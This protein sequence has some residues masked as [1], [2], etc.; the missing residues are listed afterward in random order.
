[1]PSLRSA[2]S[3]A[4]LTALL[5]L[6]TLLPAAGDETVFLTSGWD[7][8]QGYFEGRITLTTDPQDQALLRVVRER[9][10]EDQRL[11]RLEGRGRAS[12]NWVRA[13][14]ERSAG[15]AG[16]LAGEADSLPPIV[17]QIKQERGGGVWTESLS[18]GERT[19]LSRGALLLPGDEAPPAGGAPGAVPSGAPRARIDYPDDSDFVEQDLETD[20]EPTLAGLDVAHGFKRFP[21]ALF[22]KGE[23]DAHAVSPNDVAQGALGNCYL[24]AALIATARTDPDTIVSMI[25]DHQD[26]TYTVTFQDLGPFRRGAVVRVSD[27]IPVD[28]TG[29]APVFVGFGDSELRDGQRVRE[30]WPSV[31]EKAWAK[32]KG[33]YQRTGDFYS[34]TAFSF[35]G[36][37]A[38][39]FDPRDMSDAQLLEVLRRA[40]REGHPMTLG[41]DSPR[42]MSAEASAAMTRLNL[43]G[44]H[45]YALHGLKGNR[46]RL[47]NPWGHDHP[48]RAIKIS[49]IRELFASMSQGRY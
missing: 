8:T 24:L 22:I 23:G 19:S 46:V 43:H 17:M 27:A 37:S 42:N 18:D 26:G 4:P 14:F 9:R 13:L 31:I 48:T 20:A 41:T 29:Q 5:F 7:Y 34:A 15:A 12:G 25:Q 40:E 30:I 32:Y 10:F 44:Y 38:E 47:Y 21:S 3:L 33:S 1:M 49:E 16:R 45:A 35:L 11:E 28:R 6:A 36:G 39:G 2:P